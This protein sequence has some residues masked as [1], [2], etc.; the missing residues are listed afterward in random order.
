[1][2]NTESAMERKQ[3][4]ATAAAGERSLTRRLPGGR[5]VRLASWALAALGLAA[6]STPTALP[7]ASAAQA[8]SSAANPVV[9]GIRVQAL[10]LSAAGAMLDLRYRVVDPV[11]AAPLLN[12]KVKVYL[13]DEA[14]S[15]KLGVPNSPVLGSIR[16]TARNQYIATDHTYFIMFGNPGKAVRSG[17]TVTLL[18]GD[19]KFTDVRVQ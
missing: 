2:S 3:A 9:H 7:A 16:Q 10:H 11:E 18:V 5:A 15:A 14:R 17:D 4:Q 13:V 19:Q 8:Q 1:M 6:C 12:G